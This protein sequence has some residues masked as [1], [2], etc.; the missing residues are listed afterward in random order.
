MTTRIFFCKNK[1]CD[2]RNGRKRKAY[3]PEARKGITNIHYHLRTC[4]GDD[5]QAKYVEHLNKCGG[6]LNRFCYSN[7]RGGDVFKI[8]E[9]VVIRTQPI[10][11]VDNK[12]TRALL[13]VKPV[14]SKSLQKYIF[15]LTSLVRD[16][17][18]KT[19]PNN[20]CVM[21]CYRFCYLCIQRRVPG[22]NLGVCA[23]SNKERTKCIVIQIGP[24][25]DPA[26]IQQ[27]YF[28]FCVLRRRQLRGLDEKSAARNTLIIG[29]SG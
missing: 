24:R 11:K 22:D 16:A 1:W 19:L 15:S 10:S 2:P 12:L 14:S 21:L 25:G 17:M 26:S 20:F 3:K 13:S 7:A 4:V 27:E 8:S 6:I 29:C 9:W 5:Y 28:E 18:I 23:A